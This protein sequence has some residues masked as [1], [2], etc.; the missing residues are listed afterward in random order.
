MTAGHAAT[1]KEALESMRD[2]GDR[3]GMHD[4]AEVALVKL[5]ALA[6]LVAERDVAVEALEQIIKP[7][8]TTDP[9]WAVTRAADIARAA[10]E[11]LGDK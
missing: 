8:N 6:A 4:D 1:I 3:P 9:F 2:C 5:A 7:F 10:L 11:R